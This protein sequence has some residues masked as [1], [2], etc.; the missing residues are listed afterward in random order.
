[1]NLQLN[2]D[3]DHTQQAEGNELKEIKVEGCAATMLA[4]SRGVSPKANKHRI[5]RSNETEG[6]PASSVATHERCYTK[7]PPPSTCTTS[8]VM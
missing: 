8:P 7:R 6:A 1:M 3:L 5:G 4:K 2:W